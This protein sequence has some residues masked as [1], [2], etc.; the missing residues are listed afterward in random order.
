MKKTFTPAL[1]LAATL[2]FSAPSPFAAEAD[3]AQIE[4]IRNSLKVFLPGLAE[5]QIRPSV[6]PGLY[7]VVFQSRL[8][9]VSADGRYLVQGAVFDLE[10]GKDITR[11]RLSALRAELVNSVGE[12]NMLIYEPKETRHTITV[13]TDIDCSYCRKLH[14]EMADYLAQGIRVR[15][16]LYPRA[17]LNSPSY[18][19]AVSV[20]C[21]DDRHGAMDRAKQGE[22][23]EPKS[24]DNP[25]ARHVEIGEQLPVRGTPTLVLA[26]GEVISGY[27]PAAELRQALD[28]LAAP[29]Q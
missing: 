29:P 17:G 21:A 14:S 9:Y 20:W 28:Q 4:R 26:G 6:V 2:L 12:D 7:E 23:L 8:L 22:A 3:E 19:K 27:R 13:F 10:Q 11:P 25:V 15:Y 24:C 1:I 5:E 18:Q 16:L